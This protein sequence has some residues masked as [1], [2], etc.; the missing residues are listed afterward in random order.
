MNCMRV[1]RRGGVLAMMPEARLS[2]IGEFED[3]Q[4]STFKFLKHAS[5]PVYY[6]KICGDYLASPKWGDGLR[7]GAVVE[8]TLD[9]LFTKEEIETLDID[10]IKERTLEKLYYN[11]MEFLASRPDIRYRKRTLAK[12]LENI[13]TICPKCKRKYTIYT[14]NRTVGCTE[15]GELARLDDRYLFN[16]GAPFASFV[17]WYKWQREVIAE[18]IRSNPDYTLSSSVEYKLPSDDGKTFLRHAGYG[19]CTLSREGLVYEGTRDGENVTL[20]FPISEIYRLLFGAGVNFEVYVKQ[21]IHFF[22]PKVKSSS[23]DWYIASSIIYDEVVDK[24][25]R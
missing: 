9:L 11:E 4:E 24:K 15:C 18:E 21:T 17:D 7:R 2:T 3:I 16:E 19:T 22:V 14:K 10:Q 20:H 1:L 13:L 12:G 6:I 25:D 5:V 23:V 8:T